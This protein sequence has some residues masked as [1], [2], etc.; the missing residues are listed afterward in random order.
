[1]VPKTP[2]ELMKLITKAMPNTMD[3]VR[4]LDTGTMIASVKMTFKDADTPIVKELHATVNNDA[5]T[6][7]FNEVNIDRKTTQEKFSFDDRQK[8]LPLDGATEPVG[9]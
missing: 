9:E 5:M 8:I 1:M 2:R 4:D 6:I 3:N 7:S